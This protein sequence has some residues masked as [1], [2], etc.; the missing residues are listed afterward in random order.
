MSRRLL[1][2][3]LSA[4]FAV[5]LAIAPVAKADDKALV[6]GSGWRLLSFWLWPFMGS[7]GTVNPRFDSETLEIGAGGD[8]YGRATSPI[9]DP[10]PVDTSDTEP[11]H[12]PF[13]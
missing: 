4:A 5:A 2:T 13:G 6:F 3:S 9:P 8:P 1:R 7:S 10:I 12:D 11:G